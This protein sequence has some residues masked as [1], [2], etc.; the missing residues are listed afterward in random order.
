[1]N[2][3]ILALFL[4]AFSFILK[5]QTVKIV[6][7]SELKSYY[8]VRNDTTY[9][10]NFWATW[11]RPCL[12]EL[13]L[14]EQIKKN[15]SD[16]KVKVLL[17]SLDFPKQVGKLKKFLTKNKIRSKVVLLDEPDENTW[18]PQINEKWTGSIPATLIIN[19]AKN[20]TFFHE[21]KLTLQELEN[22]IPQ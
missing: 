16:E 10:V 14:F 19:N 9:V 7:L 8:E 4:I 20:Y 6:S 22:A 17:V 11:C 15:H 2:K 5:A 13:P 3:T 18:I 12:E 1:M 21:G